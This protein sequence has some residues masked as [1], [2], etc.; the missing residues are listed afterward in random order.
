[1][2]RTET[3]RERVLTALDHR[4]PARVPFAW[5]FGTTGEMAARMVAHLE[6]Q[7]IVWHRLRQVTGDIQAIAGPDLGPPPPAGQDFWG[8]RRQ[9]QSYGDGAYSE[10]VDFLLAGIDTV[11]EMEAY[12]WPDP[13]RFGAPDTAALDP[14]RAV[15]LHGGNPFEIYCW[16][17]GLE[18]SLFNLV[19]RPAVVGA[20][21]DAI[22]SFFERRLSRWLEAAG[23]RVD[24]VFLADDLGGQTGPLLS[25]GMYR[26]LLQPYHRRLADV[27]HDT[28]LGARAM[29]HTD[30]SVYD[31]LPDL[32]DAGV[33]VLEAVQVDCAGMDPERLKAEFGDRLS[34][35]GAISVQQLLPR[36]TADQVAAECRRLVSVFGRGGGYIAA[37]AHAIQVGT[38]PE[39]VLAMLRAVLGDDDYEEAVAASRK[40]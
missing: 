1:M 7:G 34:F 20:A 6:P 36:A 33:D 35:H 17:T 21:M 15:R 19:E 30:G 5:G 32:L 25:P 22:T 2:D 37:P 18:E 31:L 29:Y 13:G 4:Q 28:A 24:L 3:P 11:A 39:N 26:R 40:T 16:L 38:P 14:D 10:F 23:E 9:T 27:V 12:P 8:I